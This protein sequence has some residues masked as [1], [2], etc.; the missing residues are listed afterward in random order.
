MIR[1]ALF[2]GISITMLLGFTACNKL[3]VIGDKSISSFEELLN[4]SPD[5]IGLDSQY[6]SWSFAAPDNTARFAWSTD[7]NMTQS[8]D[9]F[10]EFDAQP[11]ID[12]GMDTGSLQGGFYVIG[13][14]IL[15]GV[16]LSNETLSYEGDVTPM[17]SYRYLVEYSRESIKY[18]SAMDHYGVDLGNGNMFEWA[19]D[20]SK[21]DLDVVFALNPEPFIEAG[22]DPL[23]VEGW[24]LTKVEVM[25]ENGKMIEVDRLIKAYNID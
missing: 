25:D 23:K 10:V 22:I 2:I 3:D 21:N 13:D 19:K 6:L 14:K 4:Q 11:F 5:Q 16:D 12:A 24:E 1:Q 18:H 15:T 9:V 17:E 7:F 8:F 20:I